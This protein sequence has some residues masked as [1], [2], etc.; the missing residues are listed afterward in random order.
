LEAIFVA[1]CLHQ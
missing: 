1:T